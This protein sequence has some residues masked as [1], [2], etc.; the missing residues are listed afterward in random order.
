[1]KRFLSGLA[2]IWLVTLLFSCK[3]TK[4]INKVIAP[5][6]TI[7]VAEKSWNADSVNHIR[8]MLSEFNNN[9]ID[10]HTFSA[11]VKVNIEDSKGKQPDITAVI[12]MVKDSAIWVSLNA[13]FLNIELYRVLIKPDSVVLLNKQDKEVSYR[14]LDYL[15]EVSEIPVD[16]STL[17]N[18]LIGNPVFYTDSI[19]SY[20][21]VNGL[22]LIGSVGPVFKNLITLDESNKLMQHI[23]LDDVDV[24]RNRTAN[25]S[26]DNYEAQDA[27]AFPTTRQISISEK[28]KL[29]IK[30]K[31]KQYEFNKELSLP[32]NIPKNYKSK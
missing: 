30:L 8:A 3:A 9:R 19:S 7:A 13:T 14:S 21:E 28:N 32:F 31:F 18:L 23:K 4:Q 20:R 29:D 1:M 15:Q 5:K 11:K 27:V 25:I 22:I 24:L 26:Y 16:F 10:F 6:D 2:G 17:Q 12:R